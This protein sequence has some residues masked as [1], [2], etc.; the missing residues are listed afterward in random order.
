MSTQ[1][2]SKGQEEE[3]GRLRQQ[4]NSLTQECQTLKSERLAAE[5]SSTA[6]QNAMAAVENDLQEVIAKEQVVPEQ[7]KV[8]S[9]TVDSIPG[10]PAR[11]LTVIIPGYVVRG[12]PTTIGTQSCPSSSY[13]PV[14]AVLRITIW[15]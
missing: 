11:T 6:T 9:A 13:L 10:K 5:L 7:P 4:V 8:P 2:I 14:Y 15:R 12:P 1:T 3:L